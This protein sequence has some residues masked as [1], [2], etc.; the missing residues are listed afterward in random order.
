MKLFADRT[1]CKR[2]PHYFFAQRKTVISTPANHSVAERSRDC[3]YTKLVL[4][5]V[6]QLENCNVLYLA[7]DRIPTRR[8]VD[9]V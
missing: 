2:L 6:K 9:G 1:L 7:R 4:T 3:R 5:Q 8:L